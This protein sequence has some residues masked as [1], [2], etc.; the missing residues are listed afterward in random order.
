MVFKSEIIENER[1]KL[2]SPGPEES[3]YI[4]RKTVF[5]WMQAAQRSSDNH[6]LEYCLEKAAEYEKH[7]AVVFI[8][9]PSYPEANRR[10]FRFMLEGLADCAAG[11]AERGIPF[12]LLSGRPEDILPRLTASAFLL[13]CDGGYLRHQRKWRRYAAE[14]AAC[15]VVE[16]E[17]NV[18]I[19]LSSV[20]QKRE[21][22]AR[23]IRPK[24][25]ALIDR[26]SRPIPRLDA[27]PPGGLDVPPGGIRR[28]DNGRL[29]DPAEHGRILESLGITDGPESVTAF[30]RGGEREA[31]ARFSRFID[32]YLPS[33]ADSANDPDKDNSSF[34]SPYLHFGHISPLSLIL[35]LNSADTAAEL[36][37]RSAY[38]EQ[39]I[40]RRELAHNYIRYEPR[41]D[42][43]EALPEWAR[44][45]LD[46]HR[47]DR[48]EI[49]Y[50]LSEL[51]AGKTADIYWN[52]AM[53]EMRYTG[54]MQNYMRMYWGKKILE[55]SPAPEEAYKRILYL[56]NKYF[57]DGRDCLSYAN[58][59]WIF[60]LHDRPWKERTLFGMVRY[61]NAAGLK[62]KFDINGYVEKVEA[63][64]IRLRQ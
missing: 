2:L 17:T 4:R 33:Y 53:E 38:I 42:S 47:H 18:L 25:E 5:Y 64:K 35:M 58:T 34:M 37:G 41:Y 36:T 16:I 63:A 19:S 31:A 49:R 56:N 7:V 50:S 54:Y 20:S 57:L 21:Y 43:Y 15:P 62:R 28:I 52:A 48:R 23:T 44:K 39:C 61:M 45:T 13:V 51:E 46:A 29:H 59:G 1:V 9:M 40:V 14:Q 60:G 6:A 30:F 32:R 22:A 26:F 10:H 55:W 24:I 27:P 12:Y 11:C 3:A 8:I